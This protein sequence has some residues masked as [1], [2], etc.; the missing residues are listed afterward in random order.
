[1]ATRPQFCEFIDAKDGNIIYVNPYAVRF[2]QAV[3]HRTALIFSETHAVMVTADLRS[4]M[5]AGLFET[6]ADIGE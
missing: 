4:V 6:F 3:G 2:V 5:E 1:M